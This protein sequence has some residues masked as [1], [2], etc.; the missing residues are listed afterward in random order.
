MEQVHIF[1]ATLNADPL[2]VIKKELLQFNRI[3]AL[4]PPRSAAAELCSENLIPSTPA[5]KLNSSSS[6]VISSTR[7]NYGN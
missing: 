3:T 7:I 6:I 4:L 1:I 5:T 2:Q